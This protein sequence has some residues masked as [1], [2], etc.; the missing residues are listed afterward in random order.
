MDLGLSGRRVVITGA[1]KGIGLA[2][3]HAFAAEGAAV[4]GLARS[5]DGLAQ[6]RE[7]LAAADHAMAVCA[8]DL[9]D[10]A[11]TR[12]IFDRI[13]AEHGPVD[14]LVNSAGAARRRPPHELDAAALHEAMDAKYFTYMHA[15]DAVI[16]AMAARGQGAIVNV[17]GQGGRQANALHIGGGAANAALMLATVGYAQAYAAQG[18]RVNAINPGITRTARM[19]EGLAAAMRASGID[20]STAL[21]QQMAGVP[22]G[23]PAEPA[24]VADLAVYPASAR[25][26]YVTGAIVPMDGGKASVI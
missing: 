16:R 2:C 26:A 8:V 19:E 24:E 5:A 22:M 23:R 18:V 15:V 12:E 1:S 11:A 3:A 17:I 20:R 25:A 6:A 9:R 10:A 21:A 14:V 13:A 4:V 7:A